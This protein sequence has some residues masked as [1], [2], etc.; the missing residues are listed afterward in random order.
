MIKAD[1]LNVITFNI[2]ELNNYVNGD[3]IAS[4]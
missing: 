3:F 2:A 4:H 1:L